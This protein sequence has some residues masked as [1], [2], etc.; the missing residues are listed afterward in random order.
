MGLYVN[1]P[2]NGTVNVS[3]GFS[4]IKL[5]VWGPG[6]MFLQNNLNPV[7]EVT[8]TGPKV[9]GCSTGSGGS[10]ITQNLTANLKNGAGGFYTLPLSGFTVKGLCGNDSVAANVLAKLA[11]VVVTIPGTSFNYTNAEGGNYPT[12]VNLGPIG[13]TNN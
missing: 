6:P 4:K 3:S 7:L 13:F 9:A 10:E 2:N 8:L 12:G 1:A 11:R 5:K